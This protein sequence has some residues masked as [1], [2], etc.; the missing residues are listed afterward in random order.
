MTANVLRNEPSF[1][2]AILIAV[3]LTMILFFID[4]GYYNFNWMLSA[5]NWVVFCIYTAI[6]FAGQLIIQLPVHYF[7]PAKFK[8]REIAVTLAGLF[9][10]VALLYVVF[11]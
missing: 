10:G 1:R 4:E 11:W 2:G 8:Y 7:L 5:G 3:S 9:V 6:I